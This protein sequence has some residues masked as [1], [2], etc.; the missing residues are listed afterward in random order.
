LICAAWPGGPVATDFECA[1]AQDLLLTPP[2]H[3]VASVD[4]PRRPLDDSKN[5]TKVQQ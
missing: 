1:A 2:H 3:K 5:L 4:Q